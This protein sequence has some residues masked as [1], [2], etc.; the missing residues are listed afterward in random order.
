MK[1]IIAGSRDINLYD[2]LCKLISK[3]DISN[4]STIISG[5]AKGVDKLGEEYAYKNNIQ[6]EQYPAKWDMYGKQ[7][8]MI[9]NKEMSK[10]ADGL[11]VLWNDKSKGTKNMI[12]IMRKKGAPVFGKI[13]GE[14][15]KYFKYNDYTNVNNL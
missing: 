14:R 15:S 4:I 10:I 5:C 6:L 11:I 1:Y 2:E 13:L 12:D 8:G 9:R 7:A 3:F